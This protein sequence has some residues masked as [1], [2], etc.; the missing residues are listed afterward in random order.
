MQRDLEQQRPPF[1]LDAVSGPSFPLTVK[2][3]ATALMAA[4][5]VAG[6]DALAGEMPVPFRSFDVVEWG[7][8]TAIVAVI[9]ASYWGILT[10]RTRCDGISIEQTWLWRKKVDI[11]DITQL[12]LVGLAGMDWLIVPRLVVRTGYGLTT[13]QAADPAVLARFRLLAHGG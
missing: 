10:S 8:L 9:G 3:L 11:A 13:F 1:P 5:V 2:V 7:F 12:K 4:L 6:T